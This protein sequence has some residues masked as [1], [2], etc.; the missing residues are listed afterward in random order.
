MPI[1]PLID[2]LILLGWTSLLGAFLLKAIWITTTYRPTVFGLLP[3]DFLVV[4]GVFLL[5]AMTLAA[6]TWVKMNEP[7]LLAR[8]RLALDLARQEADEAG[9]E[10]AYAPARFADGGKAPKPRRPEAA[11]GR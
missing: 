8:R 1:L 3:F 6:R 2:L 4:A 11:A 5:F 7:R 10:E 9:L